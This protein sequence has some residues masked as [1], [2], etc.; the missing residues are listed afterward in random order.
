MKEEMKNFSAKNPK[1]TKM[2]ISE[3]QE[4]LCRELGSS[5]GLRASDFI[6]LT[7]CGNSVEDASLTDSLEKYLQKD[8]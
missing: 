5:S 6:V 1:L 2:T 7:I 8:F 4:E 3:L